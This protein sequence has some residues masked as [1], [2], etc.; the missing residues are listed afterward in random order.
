MPRIFALSRTNSSIEAAMRQAD[1]QGLPRN[2]VRGR[3]RVRARIRFK[4]SIRTTLRCGALV[5]ALPSAACVTSIPTLLCLHSIM[6][7]AKALSGWLDCSHGVL[8]CTDR[9][10]RRLDLLVRRC[11]KAR[12]A[13]YRRDP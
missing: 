3:V 5:F 13:P 7:L 4:V 2:Q 10:S 8:L 1:R 11:H 12:P 6:S 9:Q